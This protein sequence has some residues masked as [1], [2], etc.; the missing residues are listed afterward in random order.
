MSRDDRNRGRN[1][2]SGKWISKATGRAAACWMHW[3]LET[4]NSPATVPRA[5]GWPFVT[6]S[7]DVRVCVSYSGE[8]V[9]TPLRASRQLR[10]GTGVLVYGSTP[11]VG[12][13]LT[14]LHTPAGITRIGKRPSSGILHA[15]ECQRTAN[16]RF[17]VFWQDRRL[18]AVIWLASLPA[19]D[20]PRI[21]FF[22][23]KMR[24]SRQCCVNFSERGRDTQQ[25]T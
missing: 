7:W 22:K 23:P 25:N 14:A 16:C 11:W 1:R 18:H 20:F 15:V 12:F 21:C 5:R 2:R 13:F 4:L 24:C 6:A 8:R 10:R 19:L 9:C 17:F 3:R